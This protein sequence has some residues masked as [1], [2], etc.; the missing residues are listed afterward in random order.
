MTRNKNK[1]K[2]CTSCN[3]GQGEWGFHWKDG[4]KEWKNK[5]G[6]NPSVHFSNP[7]N[8][9]IIYCS[10][11]INTIEESMED[12]SKGRDD[13]QIN[14]LIPLG[15]FELLEWLL[16]KACSPL[17]LYFYYFMMSMWP[18]ILLEREIFW[19]WS[20]ITSSSHCHNNPVLVPPCN[21]PDPVKDIYDGQTY[22]LKTRVDIWTR[23]YVVPVEYG[24][25]SQKFHLAMC[26]F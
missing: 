6:K 5:Q 15:R 17:M 8:N 1:Y 10:H 2:C 12:E 13:S 26:F 21:P 20:L 9:A 3:N 16:K 19:R 11:L 22:D 14:D 23:M 18:W 25:F 24:T 7:T 4:H